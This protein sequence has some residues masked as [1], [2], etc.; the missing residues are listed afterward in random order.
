MSLSYQELR[1][2]VADA[3]V[4]V[5]ARTRLSPLGGPDDKI[6]PP[7]Y[8]GQG[9]ASYAAE[10]R[11]VDGSTVHAVVLDSVASQ[12]NHQELALLTRKMAGA[13][14]PAVSVDFSESDAADLD[15]ITSLEASH[16]VFD[17]IFRDSLNGDMLFR[18]SEEGRAVTE[19]TPKNAA[20]LLAFSPTT[21]LFGGWD[22]TGPKGGLGAKYERAITSEIV[23]TGVEYG[24]KTASRLDA[25][26]IEKSAGPVLAAK[27]P[28][29]GWTMDTDKAKADKKGPVPY[30]TDK[31]GESGRPSMV[32]H[33]NV[34]PS[35]DSDTGGVTAD[36]VVATSVLSF[37]QLRR[38]R[39]PLDAAG[40]AVDSDARPDAEVAARTALA[41]LGLLA[42]AAANEAG[43]DLRS[44]CVLVA[45][46][47]LTFELVGRTLDDVTSFQLTA[48]EAQ[49]LLDEAVAEV[50]SHGLQWNDTDLVLQPT[51][52]LLELLR[53]SR[54]LAVAV[55]PSEDD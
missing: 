18:L 16:R 19:A 50:R 33:G 34:A 36:E 30:G 3:H 52:K 5:R 43:F 4:G 38:L 45:H 25:L 1:S 11:R 22:S 7:T 49:L 32:N 29:E 23:A 28:D 20:A 6:F 53:R 12:A 37:A 39:F 10:Q 27:D 14:V 8:L 26:G 40:T 17:A 15:Q 47:T 54:E 2:A 24:K 35:I 9:G 51:P 41:A 31:P 46:T 42:V 21:L 13:P 48:D 44:R 55:D